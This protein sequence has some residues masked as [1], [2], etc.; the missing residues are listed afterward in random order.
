MRS[1]ILKGGLLLT[2]LGWFAAQ[3]PLAAGDIRVKSTPNCLTCGWQQFLDLVGRVSWSPATNVIAYDKPNANGYFDVWTINADGG[4]N[5]CLTCPEA[6][7]AVLGP[8]NKGNPAW[9]PSGQF[10]AFEVQ[11]SNA[12]GPKAAQN[13]FPGSGWSNN[14]WIM[15]AAGQNFWRVT[16]LTSDGGVIY[17]RFS[18]DGT[19]LA[20]GQRTSPTPSLW[21]T[22]Q[23]MVGDFVVAGGV[24]SVQ[25]IQTYTPSYTPGISQYYYEPHSFSADN[26]TVYFM[27]NIGSGGA[28]FYTGPG[29]MGIYG[30]TLAT[31]Q[32]TQLVSAPNEWQEFPTVMPGGTYLVYFSTEDTQ[33]SVTHKVVGDL[34][35]VS[36]DGSDKYRLTYFNDPNSPV[37]QPNGIL[38]ADPGWSP[39]ASHI[40]LYANLGEAQY[41]PGYIWILDLEPATTTVHGASFVRPPLAGGTVGTTFG[42]NLASQTA[43]APSAALPTELGGTTASFTDTKGNTFP[44]PLYFVSA[45]QVNLVI[46]TGVSLGPGILTTTNSAGVQQRGTVEITTV[47]PG[48]YTMNQ[49]G[50]GVVAAYVQV[51]SSS[52][53]TYEPVYDC[54]GGG[55]PCT[56]MPIDVSNTSDQYFLTMFGT[57]FRGRSSLSGVSLMIGNQTLPVVYAGP[58]GQYEGMDQMNVQLP[59]SLAGAGVVNVVATVDGVSSNVV[60]I[61]IQ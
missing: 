3:Q 51:A 47:S 33:A 58:Q 40:A 50:K 60:Q 44:V 42:T 61:Q 35:M 9:N 48:F 13:D 37:Y 45:E 55:L 17:P 28:P 36:P 12:V 39:D 56:T 32:L 15:D 6:A 25:N 59:S 52:G 49:N 34:W 41:L 21:G 14:L 26:S 7:V 43:A 38:T 2:W 8:L 16:S 46:P 53:S 30:L 11:M 29:P 1:K 5:N 23:L 18:P 10:I 20:W 31:Q 54:P 27:S 24:P 19:K 57:G 22:W 4:N